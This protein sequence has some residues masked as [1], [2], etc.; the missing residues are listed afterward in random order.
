MEIWSVHWFEESTILLFPLLTI[1]SP[2]RN[3]K[4]DESR[5]TGWKTGLPYP[6]INFFLLLFF[7]SK[8]PLYAPRDNF[9]LGQYTPDVKKK[10][11][12]KTHLIEESFLFFYR[13]PLLHRPLSSIFRPRTWSLIEFH[14]SFRP[15]FSPNFL[16]YRLYGR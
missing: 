3:D 12:L 5:E 14:P 4:S 10:S 11:R 6:F 16:S 8:E 7:F 13:F 15:L 1:Y 2:R 9:E